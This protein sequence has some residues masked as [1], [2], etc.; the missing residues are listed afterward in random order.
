MENRVSIWVPGVRKVHINYIYEHRCLSL[1]IRI[2]F[3]FTCIGRYLLIYCYY[4]SKISQKRFTKW[5]P[6]EQS[7]LVYIRSNT[8]IPDSQ[9]LE[10][11]KT[12]YRYQYTYFL[13]FT[14]HIDQMTIV[15]SIMSFCGYPK[16]I[17][18]NIAVYT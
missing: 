9:L 17:P 7:L 3:F 1:F 12:K 16:W 15:K 8:H 4:L 10:K 11:K 5:I 6:F 2:K 13:I 18:C 14:I